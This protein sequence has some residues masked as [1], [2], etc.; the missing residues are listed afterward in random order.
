MVRRWLLIGG[1]TTQVYILTLRQL[2]SK[3]TY[4][5]MAAAAQTTGLPPMTTSSVRA[6]NP[7][8]KHTDVE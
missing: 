4:D 7:P 3:R 6:P 5:E 8:L 2:Q 1:N